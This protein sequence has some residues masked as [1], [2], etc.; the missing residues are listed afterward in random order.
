MIYAL[1]IKL[2][3]GLY[4]EDEW[5]GILE[6][7]SSSTLNDL[8]EAIQN[9][10]EFYNDHLYEFYVSRTER[11]RERTR[12]DDE[13]GEIYTQTIEGIFPLGKDRKL[14]YMFDYGDNWIFQVSL[15]RRKPH[16]PTPGVKYP[17]FINE[18]GKKPEQYPNWDE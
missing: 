11:S 1:R 12:F 6:I 2:I 9:A 13:N 16:L 17:R 3:F 10:V 15:G 4:I 8:H 7:D 5:E 14:F 18:V